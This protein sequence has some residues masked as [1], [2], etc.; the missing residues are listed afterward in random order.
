MPHGKIRNYP[1]F[2]ENQDFTQH[3]WL[4]SPY[5]AHHTIMFKTEKNDIA[6]Q[7]APRLGW[8]GTAD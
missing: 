4:I 5:M 2:F 3:F 6:L 7:T 8:R 1:F